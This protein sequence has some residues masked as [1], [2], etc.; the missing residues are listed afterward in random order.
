MGL[1][2]FRKV[3]FGERLIIL[4]NILV[5]LKKMKVPGIIFAVWYFDLI[6]K[7][8]GMKSEMK[9]S[10]GSYSSLRSQ[11]SDRSTIIS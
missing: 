6:Q 7:L 11:F 1:N 4:F 2:R 5:V 10:Q 3:F 8:L 9:F